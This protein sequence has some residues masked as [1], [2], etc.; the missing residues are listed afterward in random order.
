MSK[1][2]LAFLA[3]M[4]TSQAALAQPAP[5][6]ATD[7]ARSQA[8]VETKALLASVGAASAAPHPLSQDIQSPSAIRVG[9]S[10]STRS[11]SPDWI[12]SVTCSELRRC[13]GP[14]VPVPAPPCTLPRPGWVK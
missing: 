6:C 4:A 12:S 1:H 13:S 8:V 3:I 5:D 2:T 10:R 14:S 9:A 7:G 11:L